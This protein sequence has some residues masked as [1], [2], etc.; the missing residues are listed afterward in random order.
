MYGSRLPHQEDEPRVDAELDKDWRAHLEANDRE[1]DAEADEVEDAKTTTRHKERRCCSCH[2]EQEEE[3]ER[4][5]E[6]NRC[7]DIGSRRGCS[8]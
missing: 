1:P 8:R 2:Q 7:Y 6:R 3:A 5:K 4:Y